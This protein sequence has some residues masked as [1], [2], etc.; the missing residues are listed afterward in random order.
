MR[1]KRQSRGFTLIELLVVVLI[2][3]ILAAVAIPQY[4]LV[5]EKG[6]VSEVIS[7]V[8]HIKT[9]QERVGV[10]GGNYAS[11]LNALDVSV[12][13]LKYFDA[14]ATLTGGPVASGWQVTFNRLISPP[15][16]SRYASAYSVV[17][18]SQTG[19]YSS[20]DANVLNDLLPQ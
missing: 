20:N 15:A 5:V 16:P 19:A 2:I 14:H 17:F 10:N 1:H 9:A 18:N 11:D 13:A 6:R 3:G 7:F 4:F 8:G 12:P